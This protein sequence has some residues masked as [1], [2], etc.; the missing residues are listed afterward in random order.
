MKTIY[1]KVEI[2]D[3]FEDSDRRIFIGVAEVGDSGVWV[4][5]LD[6]QYFTLPTDREI[7]ILANGEMNKPHLDRFDCGAKWLKSRIENQ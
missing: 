2:P 7:D 4:G 6:H 5:C 1:L 3:D